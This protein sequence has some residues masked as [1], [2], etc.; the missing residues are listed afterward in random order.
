MAA[1]EEA[2]DRSFMARKR[3]ANEKEAEQYVR[4]HQQKLIEDRAT[5]LAGIAAK[6]AAEPKSTYDSE[7][8]VWSLTELDG[9]E[10]GAHSDRA[11]AWSLSGLAR[12]FDNMIATEAEAEAAVAKPAAGV[13]AAAEEA[14]AP[15]EAEAAAE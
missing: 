12:M 4:L 9:A 8:D 11:G 2:R 15:A 14:P 3:L 7:V 10:P 1:D 5:E 13:S 6:L